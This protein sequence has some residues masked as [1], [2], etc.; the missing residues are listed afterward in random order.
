MNVFKDKVH[1]CYSVVKMVLWIVLVTIYIG[2]AETAIIQN[3][4]AYFADHQY[5][6]PEKK[7]L[8]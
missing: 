2:K 7:K 3:S 6:V 1:H 5:E 4:P 8:S